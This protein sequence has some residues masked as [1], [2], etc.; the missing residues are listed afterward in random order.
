[1]KSGAGFVVT[2]KHPS[3]KAVRVEVNTARTWFTILVAVPVVYSVLALTA[4]AL[5]AG[6]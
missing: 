4:F 3:L 6:N 5:F 1:V 2:S